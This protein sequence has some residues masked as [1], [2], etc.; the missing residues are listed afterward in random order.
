MFRTFWRFNSYRNQVNAIDVVM[1]AQ[2]LVES[3]DHVGTLEGSALAGAGTGAGTGAGAGAG[4][5]AGTTGAGENS[6]NGENGTTVSF[7]S[8]GSGTNNPPAGNTRHTAFSDAYDCMGMKNEVLL[9]QGID[10]AVAVQKLIV[11][12]ARVMLDGSDAMTKL[13]NVYWAKVSFE[14]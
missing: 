11:S 12:R 2:M 5:G 9:K 1:A 7:S 8:G 13:R 10:M 6:I 3:V 14:F 4:T